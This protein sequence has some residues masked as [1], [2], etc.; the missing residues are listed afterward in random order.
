[1]HGLLTDDMGVYKETPEG[2]PIYNWQYIDE[3]FDFLLSINIRPFVELGFMPKDLASG[4]KSVFWWRGNICPPKDY[5][6]WRDLVKALTEHFTE[7]YGE[8]EVKQWYFEVWNEPNLDIFWA[9]TEQEYYR[10]YKKAAKAIKGVCS[11]Y[12]VGG[13]ATAGNAWIPEFIKFCVDSNVPVDFVSTHAY[14]VDVGFVDQYGDRGTILS[15][16]PDAVSSEMVHVREQIDASPLPNLELH[17]TEWSS[18]YTPVDPIHDSFVQAP[19]VLDKIKNAEKSLNS[20]SY[21]TFT[22]IFEEIGPR[23]TPFHGGFGLL[24]YQDIC[25]PAF[26]AFQYRGSM[27][28]L[29][30][31]CED[32]RAIL[33]HDGV[34]KAEALFW[35][36]TNNQPDDQN[37]QVYYKQ[38][39]PAAD[40]SELDFTVKNL[41]AGD[42]RLTIYRIGRGFNDPYSTYLELGA[43]SQL[44]RQQVQKLKQASTGEPVS[45]EIVRI[46]ASG[47]FERQ[48]IVR[49][50]DVYFVTLAKVQ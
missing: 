18:S 7:R 29:E 13:P 6:K 37:N 40:K 4:E 19:Y 26:H 21:W 12:R 11:E 35:D 10:L 2:T 36:F 1:M 22:D 47:V 30:Q 43:P 16:N 46:G 45:S 27:G 9:G 41:S 23:F 44:T 8:D 15:K 14:G 48:F 25:K 34:G 33:A 38:D 42:Y 17:Y 24:N 3:V 28:E 39:Q 50:N 5:A 32:E 20:M 49:E 31:A